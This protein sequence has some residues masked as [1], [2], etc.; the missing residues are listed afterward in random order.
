MI[1]KKVI[2]LRFLVFKKGNLLWII[3]YKHNERVTFGS[4]Q[5]KKSTEKP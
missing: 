5:Q 2:K 1:G 4:V 3:P